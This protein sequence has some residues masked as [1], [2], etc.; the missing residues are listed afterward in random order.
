MLN[1]K[2][3]KNQIP[4]FSGAKLKTRKKWINAFKILL[5]NY[6]LIGILQPS[7]ICIR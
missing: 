4:S 7:R 6:F 3:Y 1:I 5:E 2:G